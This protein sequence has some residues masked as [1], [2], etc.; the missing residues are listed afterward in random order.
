MTDREIIS[1]AWPE[2]EALEE[3]GQGTYGR[4]LRV[5][6]RDVK[7]IEAAVKVIRVPADEDEID[8]LRA[9]GLGDEQI[10]AHLGRMTEEW[11]S[12]IR[13]MKKYQG[14]SHFVSIEDCRVL[15]REDGRPGRI[16]LIRMELLKS[17]DAY[18][19][20]KTL[21]EPEVIGLGLQLSDALAV[22]HA[23]GL[24]HRDVKPGNIFVSDRSSAGTLF[25]LG[26]FGVTHRIGK[27][28]DGVT[29]PG[30]PAYMAPEAVRGED[31]DGRA[32]I[33]SL[34]LT[35]YR[36]MNG[37]RLPFMPEHRL[38]TREDRALAQRMRM[39]G[40]PLPPASGASEG[41]RRIL[42]KACAFAPEDRY[43]SAAAFSAALR[44]LM[45][46]GDRPRRLRLIRRVLAGVLA[47][48]MAAAGLFLLLRGQGGTDSPAQ[49]PVPML[50]VFD[51]RK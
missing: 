47:A 20:D 50:T 45:K 26:D 13:I 14:M 39:S 40:A 46:T 35:L 21:T 8:M 38:L 24:V 51:L 1:S 4:V 23:D 43:A 49:T 37:N 36:L 3:L 33:Y 2:W 18:L 42:I 41:F 19:S 22:C 16:I 34:G 27:P 10:E 15:P 6:R 29:A 7:D 9:D 25:K 17:L 44:A 12:E 48:L 28:S 31:C 11:L 32:D 30:A 5:R